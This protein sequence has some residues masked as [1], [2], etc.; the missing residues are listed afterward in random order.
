MNNVEKNT[1]PPFF[2]YIW[3]LAYA[4]IDVQIH[5]RYKTMPEP[6]MLEQNMQDQFH[7]ISKRLRTTAWS[8]HQNRHSSVVRISQIFDLITYFDYH[9]FLVIPLNTLRLVLG[10]PWPLL[11]YS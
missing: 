6:I 1:Y 8:T 11:E 3:S 7:D 2:V 4:W 5:E 9:N 10:G